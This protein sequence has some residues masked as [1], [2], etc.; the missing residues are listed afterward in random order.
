MIQYDGH[1]HSLYC[2]HGSTDT[3]SQ[4][5]EKAIR[6]GLK[7]L[8][9]AEHAPLPKGFIDPTPTKDSAMD[10]QHLSSYIEDVQA[11][12]KDYKNHLDVRVGLEVDFIEGYETETTDFLN[13]YGPLLDDS[14]L[15]VHFL[16]IDNA[17][18]CLDYCP[19]TFAHCA[20]LVGSVDDLYHRYYQVVARSINA[21]LGFF[22]PTRI[23]HLTLCHKFKKKY[24]ASISYG[25]EI[26]TLLDLI[27]DKNYSIDYNGAGT[28]KPLCGQTYPPQDIAA[29]ARRLKI[30]LIYGSDA[31]QVKAMNAGVD[32]IIDTSYL[33]TPSKY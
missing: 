24:P 5:C 13:E 26:H 31:H 12:K 33:T 16:K 27:K 6:L 29:L 17:Y 28:L 4:Y 21:N 9:F 3:F 22:K 1:V 2:P 30:P 19:D 32:S 11:I 23:G 14:I 15:S 7:G 18:Y 8:T 20:Q 10:T 25:E